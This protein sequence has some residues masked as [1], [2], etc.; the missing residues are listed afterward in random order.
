MILWRECHEDFY[1]T[2]GHP[3]G[4]CCVLSCGGNDVN[5][6]DYDILVLLVLLAG[7]VIGAVAASWLG[8]VEA[9]PDA[10]L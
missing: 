6:F 1:F 9:C 3:L 7:V 10:M 8:A 4:C 2:V 5:Q